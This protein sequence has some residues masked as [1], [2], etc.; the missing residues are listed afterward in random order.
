MVTLDLL[1]CT[2]RIEGRAWGNRDKQDKVKNKDKDKETRVRRQ[3]RLCRVRG[4]C[5]VVSHCHY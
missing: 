2:P 5:S 1:T 3:G 4:S